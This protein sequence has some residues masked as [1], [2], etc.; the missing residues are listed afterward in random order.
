[1]MPPLL[2][3]VQGLVGLDLSKKSFLPSRVSRSLITCELN[4]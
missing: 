2:V 1:M 4:S 3:K